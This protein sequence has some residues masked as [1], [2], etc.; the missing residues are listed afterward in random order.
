MKRWE[1]R[2]A[3]HSPA[4]RSRSIKFNSIRKGDRRVIEPTR[5]SMKTHPVKDRIPHVER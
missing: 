2:D 4:K 1:G 3:R 5:R